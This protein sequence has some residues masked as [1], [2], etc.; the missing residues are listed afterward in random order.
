MNKENAR[1]LKSLPEEYK[2]RYAA[3]MMPLHIAGKSSKEINRKST[4]LL[5]QYEDLCYRM[6]TPVRAED[7]E[8]EYEFK[9]C[10]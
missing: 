1:I 6:F 7:C 9:I 2:R 10:I 3:A 4:E 8:P 5:L